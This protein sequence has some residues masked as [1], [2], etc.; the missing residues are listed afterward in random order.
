MGDAADD[1]TDDMALAFA[2]HQSR[3]C[4]GDCE[5][6]RDDEDEEED[7]LTELWDAH[8]AGDCDADCP[9]CPEL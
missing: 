8:L 7:D 6:C 4:G 1:L 2:L 5:F 9:W 3:R